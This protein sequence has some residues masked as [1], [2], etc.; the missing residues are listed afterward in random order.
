M[1]KFGIGSAV[2][3]TMTRGQF[4]LESNPGMVTDK[5][6]ENEIAILIYVKECG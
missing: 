4:V 3:S 2:L 6:N 5:A 1:Q